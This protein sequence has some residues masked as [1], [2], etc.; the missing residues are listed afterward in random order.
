MAEQDLFVVLGLASA[1]CFITIVD[2]LF[3]LWS[4]RRRASKS[5][6][7]GTSGSNN[8]QEAAARGRREVVRQRLAAIQAGG[9]E[10]PPGRSPGLS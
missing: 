3:S 10:T 7:G 4:H 5:G 6:T 8:P 1:A 9:R 2:L